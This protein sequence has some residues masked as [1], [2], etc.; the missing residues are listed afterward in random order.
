MLYPVIMKLIDIL[1]YRYLHRR[2]D[3]NDL[4]SIKK[5][6]K[7]W[8]LIISATFFILYLIGKILNYD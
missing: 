6:Q 1:D 5:E 4:I 8:Y 2:Y 7:K 3:D